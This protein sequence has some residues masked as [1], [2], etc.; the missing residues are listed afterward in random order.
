MTIKALEINLFRTIGGAY[1]ALEMGY[2]LLRLGDFSLLA[3]D[4]CPY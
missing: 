2:D 3:M 1:N 4:S